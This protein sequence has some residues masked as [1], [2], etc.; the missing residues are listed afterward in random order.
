MT[1][2][3]CNTVTKYQT[4]NQPDLLL[5]QPTENAAASRC[6]LGITAR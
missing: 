4:R 1:N 3:D 6:M 2:T 5:R